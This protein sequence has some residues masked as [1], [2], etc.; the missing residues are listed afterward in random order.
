MEGARTEKGV[1]EDQ[2]KNIRLN[3]KL[4]YKVLKSGGG[5][6]GAGDANA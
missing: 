5:G 3:W 2:R 6:D 4:L 1:A